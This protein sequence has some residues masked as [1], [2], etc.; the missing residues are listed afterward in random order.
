MLQLNPF[1]VY[2]VFDKETNA[3]TEELYMKAIPAT[4]SCVAKG[5]LHRLP[6]LN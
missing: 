2:K 4:N 5:L 3:S 1:L 6:P